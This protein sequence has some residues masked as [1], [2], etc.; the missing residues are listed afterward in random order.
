MKKFRLISTLI[1]FFSIL[2]FAS[3]SFGQND[4][5]G[6]QNQIK[7]K[8]QL[9]GNGFVDTNGDGYNDNAPD[10]DGDGIPNG[11]DEDYSGSKFR[12]GNGSRGFVDLNGDGINDNAIDSDGD[13]IP[14]GQDPDY[15]RP[16]DGTGQQN[17]FGNQNHRGG[18][19]WGANNGTGNNG[20][21]PAYG[22]GLGQGNGSGNCD[23]TGPKGN[24]RG[25]RR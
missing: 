13:G 24:R 7:T 21:C 2:S 14:N 6:N 1:V 19:K 5:T 9:H 12:K 17:R 16:K 3:F 8:T 20:I 11:R 15:I 22:N 23:G 10:A 25:G 4:Q 18:Y